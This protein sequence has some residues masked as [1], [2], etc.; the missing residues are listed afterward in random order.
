MQRCFD[1][2]KQGF[3]STCSNPMV[4]AV[5]C[6]DHRIIG[7]GYHETYGGPHAEVNAFESVSSE[8]RH[9]IKD[10]T[11]YVSLEPCCIH[12]KTPPCTDRIIKEGIKKVVIATTD[13]NS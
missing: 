8:D 10:S 7:E 3:K 4:G 11:I 9:L 13:P 6:H 5:L 12:G 1:L 2:A